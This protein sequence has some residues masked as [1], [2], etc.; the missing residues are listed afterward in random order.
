MTQTPAQELVYTDN[1][2]RAECFSLSL[3]Q[4]LWH[5]PPALEAARF[6]LRRLRLEVTLKAPGPGGD[7]G[8]GAGI[9]QFLSTRGL[10][11]LRELRLS[12]SRI[13]AMSF[14]NQLH[15]VQVDHVDLADD[16]HSLGKLRQTDP[17]STPVL[18]SFHMGPGRS[19]YGRKF[20]G[21]TFASVMTRMVWNLSTIIQMLPDLKALAFCAFSPYVS[22]YDGKSLDNPSFA[23]AKKLIEEKSIELFAFG[24]NDDFVD[25]GFL[26]FLNSRGPRS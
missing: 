3:R 15:A 17:D 25:R 22:T 19:G 12:C 9:E 14:L 20:P 13:P 7:E 26:D 2:P 23:D 16:E 21:I 5:F 1:S 6:K 11:C 18:I 10:P 4:S 8:W 24:C